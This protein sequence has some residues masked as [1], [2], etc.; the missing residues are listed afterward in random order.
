[1]KIYETVTGNK[2]IARLID[3]RRHCVQKAL[4]VAHD[5]V[6][7]MVL[8]LKKFETANR[9]ETPK[10]TATFFIVKRCKNRLQL[11]PASF[12]SGLNFHQRWRQKRGWIQNMLTSG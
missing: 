12:E 2:S 3:V 8:F 11:F 10:P 7:K 1:M 9:P 5:P 6:I 4:L